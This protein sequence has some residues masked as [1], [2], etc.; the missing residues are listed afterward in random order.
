MCETTPFGT[1][2][3]LDIPLIRLREGD[4]QV[5]LL[6]FGAAIRAIRVPDRQGRST[7]ICL[8]YDRIEDYRDYDACFGGTIGRCA[9]RIGG[10]AFTLNGTTHH[11]TANEGKNQLHGGVVGF[12][13]KLWRFTCAPGAVTF[14]L[15]SPDGEEGF[16]GN[17]H[18]EVTYA[19]EG[20]T[21][22]VD[23]RALSDADTVVNLTNHAYFNLAGHDGGVVADHQL[24]VH[25]AAYTPAGA[26]NVPTGEIFSVEGT[27][28]DLRTGAALGDRLEDA[29]L[30]GSRG[31][32][33][34]YV[35]DQGTAAAAELWCPRTGIGLELHTTL[36][37]MQLYTA[38]FLT[39][40]TGKSG[41]VYGPHHAVCLEP[42]FF[43]DAVNHDNFPSPVLKAGAE[44]HQT[45]RYRFFVR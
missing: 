30:V 26:G 4:V 13:K 2:E 10:A 33:H 31:Y 44:Y 23:Y 24:T 35:L 6:P 25:A 40:R 11:L 21:L 5:E 38:G 17:V 1:L 37:G 9:N 34:N 28:L 39:E 20:D 22:T 16:P 8:G 29:F 14:L 12:H 36:P 42:Q 43:P 15:D 19:L 41:V 45:I 18:T 27:P 32:D 3:G 7:D